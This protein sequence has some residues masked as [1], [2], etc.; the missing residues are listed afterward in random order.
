MNGPAA[1]AVTHLIA[2]PIL[3]PLLSAALMLLGGARWR[4]QKAVLNVISCLAGAGICTSLLV[5]VDTAGAAP[6]TWVYLP[7]N[8]PVPFGIVLVLDRLSAT[9]LVLTAFIGLAALLFALSR[10]QRAGVHFHSLFQLQLMGLN[11]AFLTGDVFNLFV[12]FEVML[13][14]SY[15][16]L[17]HGSGERRVH[18][19]LHYIAVNLVASSLFLIG[20]AM[21]YGVAGTLSLADIARK[22]GQIPS[23]DRGLLH[24]GV[25]VLGIAFIAKAAVWPLNF[26]LLPAYTAASPP[27]AALFAV[28]T[29]VG[30]Y[31]VLRI[32]TLFFPTGSS[33]TFLF[34]ADALIWI[35]LATLAFGTIGVWGAQRLD[36]VVAF[37]LIVS[38]GTLL[39]AAGFAVPEL[40]G[41][42]LYYLVGSTLAASAFF[43]LVELLERSRRLGDDPALSEVPREGAPF[44]E[45]TTGPALPPDANL[46]DE[47]R[48]LIGR[49]IPAG[50]VFLSLSFAVCALVTAGLPP[51]SGFLAKVV[52]LTAL[53]HPR[54]LWGGSVSAELAAWTFLA[55]LIISGLAAMIALVRLGI[56]YLWAPQGR[57]PP[58]LRISECLPVG[59][60]LTLCVGLVIGAGPALRFTSSAAETLLR[61][62]RYIDA[63]MSARPVPPP[64]ARKAE[65]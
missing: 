46:D 60:L 26:W 41:G 20:A 51:F 64:P 3:L 33:G 42:A 55:L 59:M 52:M 14:A 9:M 19:G 10:W 29:K 43:L 22:L 47:E 16:L 6:A 23:A 62:E 2:A 24:A 39:A 17:L 4:P 38:S 13:V 48:A 11:G 54:G 32:W 50:L 8:W 30:F 65:P 63:V 5:A 45:S 37:S 12:F 27:A 21:L 34:G 7:S 36:R 18:A 61:P 15:G 53:L 1:N 56:R 49:A 40:T 44:M 31:A 35:G 28:M 57:P 25:A 58:A